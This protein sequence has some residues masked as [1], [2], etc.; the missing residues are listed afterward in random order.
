MKT[1]K[2]KED[3]LKQKWKTTLKKTKMEVDLNFDSNKEDLQKEGRRPKI[4]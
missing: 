3:D 4:K 2:K 1:L